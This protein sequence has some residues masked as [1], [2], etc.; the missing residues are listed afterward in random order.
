MRSQDYEMTIR[1]ARQFNA[2]YVP[3]VVFLQRAHAGLRGSKLDRF[4]S[5]QQMQKWLHY[6]AMFFRDLYTKIPL[7]DF[8]PKVMLASN[9]KIARRSALLQRACVFWRRKLFEL[10]LTDM[11]E[12]I[13]MGEAGKLTSTE[14][15]ICGR[16]LHQKFGCN[17]LVTMPEIANTL[18]SLADESEFGLSAVRAVSAPLLWYVRDAFTHGRWRQGWSFATLLLRFHGCIGTASLIR[19]SLGRR[20]RPV[21]E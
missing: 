16:F 13:R 8:V 17:E 19:L 12:A 3:E 20:L 10:S 15:L 5:S 11:S 7:S 9:T 14:E 18:R 6:D 2:T 4:D 1:L 21:E